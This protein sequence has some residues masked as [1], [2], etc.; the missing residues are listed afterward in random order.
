MAKSKEPFTYTEALADSLGMD[1]PDL[2]A[3]SIMAHPLSLILNER[4]KTLCGKACMGM[5]VTEAEHQ[6]IRDMAELFFYVE[7]FQCQ[8]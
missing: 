6:S 7:N 5:P 3:V 4:D 2:M 8:A 1:A